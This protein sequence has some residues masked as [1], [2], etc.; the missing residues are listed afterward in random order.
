MPILLWINRPISRRAEPF[1]VAAPTIRCLVY[2]RQR[3]VRWSQARAKLRHREPVFIAGDS[4]VRRARAR[5]RALL[6]IDTPR[7]WRTQGEA[8]SL[9]PARGNWRAPPLVAAN[10]DR[11]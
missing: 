9:T 8:A 5:E 10:L 11:E 7:T 2:L 4:V 3:F 6:H 1:I